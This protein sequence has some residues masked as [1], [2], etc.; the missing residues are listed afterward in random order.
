ML[1]IF[2]LISFHF[3]FHCSLSHDEQA[4]RA[5]V[6]DCSDKFLAFSVDFPTSWQI[7]SK[8]TR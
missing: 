7:K 6:F 3:I 5:E 2:R 4:V 8:Q 1:T